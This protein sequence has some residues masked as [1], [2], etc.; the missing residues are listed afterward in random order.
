MEA[1]G[2]R[3]LSV[4]TG[5]GEDLRLPE[6]PP[7][8]S[9]GRANIYSPA[10]RAS[11]RALDRFSNVVAPQPQDKN[12]F[13]ISLLPGWVATEMAQHQAKVRGDDGSP[14]I[15]MDIPVLIYF[16]ACENPAASPRRNPPSPSRPQG[17]HR[18]AMTWQ[19]TAV[20]ALNNRKRRESAPDIDGPAAHSRFSTG[21]STGPAL[22]LRG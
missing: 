7:V 12:V 11:K 16:A 9:L 17:R 8:H 3:T 10:Y 22:V 18:R 5:S 21:Y 6:E 13:I 1:G 15:S 20:A 4:T 2:G 19:G 14:M